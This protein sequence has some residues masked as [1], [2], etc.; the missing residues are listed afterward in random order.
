MKKALTLS[1]LAL[2]SA[3]AI[4]SAQP[5]LTKDNIDEV[6]EAMTLEEKVNLLHG[7]PRA[8][9]V[10][11]PF[12]GA[13]GSSFAISR[14]GIPGSH[15]ADGPHRLVINPTREWDSKTYY[16]TELPSEITIAATFDTE[17]A[18]KAGEMIGSEVSDYGL[19]VLLAPGINLQRTALGG[20]NGE[21]Y[22]EDPLL[23]GKIAAG[24]INGAQSQGIGITLKHY[25]V[26][27][28]ETNR[29][30]NDAHLSQ[31]TLR[32]LY[33]KN[34]EIA[35][36]ESQPWAIMTSYNKVNGLYTCEDPALNETILREE[37][38]FKGLVMSDWNAGRD[39]AASILAGNDLLMPGQDRQ[40]A[41]VLEAVKSGRIPMEVLNRSVRR[42][43]EF[44]VK[45]H[46]FQGYDY[47]N[48]TDLKAH[49]KIA[50]EIGSE[51]IVLLKNE[52]GTLPMKSGMKVALYGTTS[53]DIVPAGMGFG[54]T[55]HGY[56]CVSLIEGLR[57]AGYSIEKSLIAPYKKHI[58]EEN[59][60]NN[61]GG[62]MGF[63]ITTPKRADEFIPDAATLEENVKGNDIAIVTFGRA[64]GEGADRLKEHFYLTDN[65]AAMLKAVSEAYHKA[66]KKVV[67]ILNVVAAVETASWKDMVDGIICAFQ[68]GAETG[69][70]IADVLSGKVNPSG[71]LPETFQINYG[72]QPAD[73][74][75]PYDYV[76]DMSAFTRAYNMGAASAKDAAESAQRQAEPELKK[77][78][79]YTDYEEGIYMGYRYFDSFGKAVSYPFGYGLSYTDF[80]YEIVKSEMG[81][82]KCTVHV[83]VS[84]VGDVAGRDVVQL[85]VKAPKGSMDK[86]AKEL[87][88]FCKTGLIKAGESE[89]VT[90]SWNTMDMAS[91]NEKASAWELAAGEY[92]FMVCKDAM[93]AASVSS[94]HKLAKK[95]MMPVNNVMAPPYKVAV[96]P[97]VAVKRK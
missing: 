30:A 88:A 15:M 12:P 97:A 51:G 18:R 47:P 25:A 34:F 46:S 48:E 59:K 33:L 55:G 74:N 77:N 20:R 54:A 82:D 79:D 84:N 28:Q 66:G 90:L 53:Y 9:G 49:S 62:G 40:R 69:N 63:S 92:N 35:V 52:A 50:R 3:S 56:Y 45:G 41:Q 65:E 24:Y 70:A 83:K 22:S 57:N 58:E 32:E 76:F 13:A 73:D 61:P 93:S 39:A 80:E 23:A 68:P 36:K 67:V 94:S 11:T 17:A 26:N 81:A 27:N 37:W 91:F 29:N 95:Q 71:R 72:D 96:H 44:V 7:Q 64:N 85:Y 60:K 1:F 6:I 86:P 5:K 14:L 38:G 19:D 10:E 42:V 8:M 43:L 89:I 87:K 75:F 78:V 31:R 16:T 2:M 21:Y 4:V